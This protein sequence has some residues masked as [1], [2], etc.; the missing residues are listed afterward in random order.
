MGEISKI[1]HTFEKALNHTNRIVV[2][3]C[4]TNCNYL[5][6]YHF[7][8]ILLFNVV[9]RVRTNFEIPTKTTLFRFRNLNSSKK[10]MKTVT[11]L[12]LLVG[13]ALQTHGG[14]CPQHDSLP[15]TCECKDTAIKYAWMDEV[16]IWVTCK[17]SNILVLINVMSLIDKKSKLKV[18]LKNM[19]LGTLPS[20]IFDGWNVVKLY[21]SHCQLDSLAP[22]RQAALAGLE[23]KL[24]VRFINRFKN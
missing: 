22:E 6:F 5:N 23:D 17:S 1:V 24:E 15:T 14:Y 20:Q 21:I 4:T 8:V 19:N 9:L 3:G 12:L 10:T 7:D 16:D 13:V 2:N 18:E 11:T